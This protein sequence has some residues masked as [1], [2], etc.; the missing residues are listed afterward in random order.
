MRGGWGWRWGARVALV[1]A[2]CGG[3]VEEEREARREG[4]SE[5][6]PLTVAAGP[7]AAATSGGTRWLQ[8]LEGVG[9]EFVAGLA[10][11]SVGN[12]VTA[13]NLMEGAA[14]DL[15]W[16]GEG[17]LASYAP[18]AFVVAKYAS[19]PEEEGSVARAA[20]ATL[21]GCLRPPS[22]PGPGACGASCSWREAR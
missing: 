2:A 15:L 9:K 21:G 1:L 6:A 19:T 13:V 17:A 16:D 14:S 5:V 10:H 8:S 3:P 4:P 22:P 12:G 20:C 7:A 11:D 18:D